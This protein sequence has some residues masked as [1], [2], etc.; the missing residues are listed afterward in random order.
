MG[1]SGWVLA[2]GSSVRGWLDC[3]NRLPKENGQ[4]TKPAGL[5]EIFGQLSQILGLI[6]ES[7]CLER[8]GLGGPCWSLP[9]YD[10][11]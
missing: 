6:L 11:L 1:A 10:T 3:W 9:T 7:F 2:E 4:G 8:V 5:K